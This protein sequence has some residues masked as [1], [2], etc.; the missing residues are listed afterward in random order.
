MRLIHSYLVHSGYRDT[1]AALDA[2][3]PSATHDHDFL[4]PFNPNVDALPRHHNRHHTQG[5]G[6]A[7]ACAPTLPPAQAQ[8]SNH[9]HPNEALGKKEAESDV[10]S[11]S[12]LSASAAPS[13]AEEES[14]RCPDPQA[15][16]HQVVGPSAFA[17]VSTS[18]TAAANGSHA[19]AE[20]PLRR[21]LS[22]RKST[23]MR[24]AFYRWTVL[25]L[26]QMCVCVG[27]RGVGCGV[28]LLCG[29]REGES[30]VHRV[31]VCAFVFASRVGLRDL[32]MSGNV[33]VAISLLESLFPGLTTAAALPPAVASLNRAVALSQPGGSLVA[34]SAGSGK[35]ETAM[36]AD[37]PPEADAYETEA[38]R[39]AADVSA[40]K[41]AVAAAVPSAFSRSSSHAL[42]WSLRAA[43]VHLLFQL[44]CQQFIE[45]VRQQQV[46]LSI[47]V[48]LCTTSSVSFLVVHPR[49]VR[50]LRSRVL[51]IRVSLLLFMYSWKTP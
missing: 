10:Q 26:T 15:Q 45:L 33:D 21:T 27:W 29:W 1:L 51:F 20:D 2:A 40:A 41:T 30:C 4:A 50:C 23:D 8:P 24:A 31:F 19:N 46:L 48:V 14:T 12:H 11:P 42:S 49:I 36:E 34:P 39:A 18:V 17:S 38:D 16:R 7:H 9:T 32:I 28:F 5:H 25:C 3:C 37:L 35:M 43:R 47:S 6:P 22:N 13:S 44:R